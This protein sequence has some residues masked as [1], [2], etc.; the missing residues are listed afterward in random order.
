M[1]I[2]IYVYA[3][4]YIYIHHCP[5][6]SVVKACIFFPF[7]DDCTA[8]DNVS[9]GL[10]TLPMSV[11]SGTLVITITSCQMLAKKIITGSQVGST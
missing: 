11:F 8:F 1:H 6:Q 10:R 9:G 2:C 7:P 5:S 4:M 3:Y